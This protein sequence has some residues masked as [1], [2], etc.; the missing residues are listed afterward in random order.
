MELKLDEPHPL[1]LHKFLT[2]NKKN[3]LRKNQAKPVTVK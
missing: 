1:P 3:I 2:G